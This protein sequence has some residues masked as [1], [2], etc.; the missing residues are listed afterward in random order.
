MGNIT[1]DII[2]LWIYKLFPSVTGVHA[3]LERGQKRELVSYT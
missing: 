2:N 3:I 1:L